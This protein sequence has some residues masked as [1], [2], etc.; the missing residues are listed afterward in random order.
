MNISYTVTC[1]FS[2]LNESS[3][4]H[5][6]RKDT[7]YISHKVN[8]SCIC[9]CFVFFLRSF[10]TRLWKCCWLV[11]TFTQKV[12][13]L[14]QPC[15]P[16]SLILVYAIYLSLLFRYRYDITGFGLIIQLSA[17]L[18]WILMEK[19]CQISYIFLLELSTLQ[20][21]LSKIFRWLYLLKN[22]ARVHG[23]PF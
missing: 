14:S 13:Y 23:K 5:T 15:I 22:V 16:T 4:K 6:E 19:K 9:F 2:V 11:P 12:R 8:S 3:S 18:W 7:A 20:M 17:V 10:E 21:S 1:T